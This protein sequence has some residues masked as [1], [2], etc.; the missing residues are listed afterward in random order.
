MS[1][2][3]WCCDKTREKRLSHFR[4]RRLC[5][6]HL[7]LPRLLLGENDTA[8]LE[9]TL[10]A[11]ATLDSVLPEACDKAVLDAVLDALPSASHG[12]DPRTLLE[13]CL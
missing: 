9:H 2:K 12:S 7:L 11:L 3:R 8:H 4:K 10:E 6:D 5:D 13:L 1:Q